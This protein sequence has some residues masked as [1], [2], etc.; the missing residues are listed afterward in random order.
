MAR[1]TVIT[2][3]ILGLLIFSV[4]ISSFAEEIIWQEISRGNM[5]INSVLVD[6]DNPRIIYMGSN[7][8]VLKTEDDGEN[9]AYVLSLRGQNTRV[10]FLRFGPQDKNSVYAATASGLFYSKNQGQ[11][12]KRI[13]RGKN[14]LENDCMGL[15]VL[16]ECIYLGTKAGLFVSYDK[17]RNWHKEKGD[18]VGSPV[19]AIASDPKEPDCV[20]IACPG[21]AYKLKD[22]GKS[23]EKIFIAS[24]RGGQEEREEET[25]ATEELEKH[26]Q[27]RYI[28]IDPPNLNYLYLATSRGVYQSQDKGDNWIRLPTYGLLGQDVRL[29]SISD[30]SLY[31]LTDSGVFEYKEKRWQELSLRLIAEGFNFLVLDHKENL[32]VACDK[33]LFRANKRFFSATRQDSPLS[34]YTKDEPSINQV[35]QA[36]IKYA[37]VNSEKIKQWRRCAKNKAWLPKVSIGLDR[38]VS[39]L[40]H[41]EGGSTTRADDDILKRGRDAVEWNLSLS[42]DLGEIIWNDDQTS[43][44]VRSRLLVELREDIL[45]E[46]TKIYFERLRVKMELDN[47]SIEDRKKRLEKELRLKELTAY[48]DALTDGYYSEELKSSATAL[49]AG[50]R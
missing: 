29:L 7:K 21:A 22:K 19:L 16:P 2:V 43:I 25:D 10:N 14:Y 37:E 17:G 31:A 24:S 38:N 23:W 49:L 40:W 50:P 41:W 18:S 11:D 34:I 33:G 12:W 13:F 47:L 4:S 48:L 15:A 45:D 28:I 42:W 39:D 6:A 26:F 32:Y 20:Y 36:A 46:V 9:W 35:Q 3:A 30:S 1:N 8:G 5:N 27:I 44:D